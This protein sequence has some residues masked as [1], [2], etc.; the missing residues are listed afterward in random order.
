MALVWY[1]TL[2]LARTEAAQPVAFAFGGEADPVAYARAMAD[3]ALLA[4]MATLGLLQLGHETTPELAQ[5]AAVSLFLYGLAAAPFRTWRARV[6]VCIALPALAASG[7]PSMALAAAAGGWLVCH[8]SRQQPVRSFAPWVL[9]AALLAL[10][11]GWALGAWRVRAARPI[12][13]ASRA[14]GCGSCGPPGRWRCGRSG[15]GGAS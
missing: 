15:A 7:A 3:G 8:L 11:A 6:A 13:P 12:C 9:G 5:L 2:L 1:S 10:A 14:S 4:L